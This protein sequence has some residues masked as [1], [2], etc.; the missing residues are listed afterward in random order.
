MTDLIYRGAT[1]QRQ[2]TTFARVARAL[3]YR[4]VP[5]DGLD[6]GATAASQPFAMRYRG[7]AY[8]LAQ[9]ATR[10]GTATAHGVERGLAPKLMFA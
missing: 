1:H 9:D 6:I 3:I 4:S 10:L 5:H 7:V 8:S 2:E